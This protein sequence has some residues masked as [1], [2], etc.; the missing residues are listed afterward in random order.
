M[1]LYVYIKLCLNYWGGY[2]YSTQCSSREYCSDY[3]PTFRL[4]LLRFF[5]MG[6]LPLKP[7]LAQVSPQSTLE[8]CETFISKLVSS[9]G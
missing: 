2:V 3:K 4:G 6:S 5:D 8:F 9:T 7:Q 1:Q